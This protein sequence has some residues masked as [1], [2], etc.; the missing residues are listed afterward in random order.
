MLIRLIGAI[1]P[2]SEH[3]PNNY[4]VQIQYTQFVFLNHISIKL[5]N[6]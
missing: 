5:E 3:I 4:I 6:I 2:Q 1:I